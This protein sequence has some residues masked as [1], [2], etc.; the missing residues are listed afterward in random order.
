MNGENASNS[1]DD[2]AFSIRKASK[3]YDN[4]FS[5]NVKM[6]LFYGLEN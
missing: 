5:V 4:G 2:G 6:A 3:G 1:G